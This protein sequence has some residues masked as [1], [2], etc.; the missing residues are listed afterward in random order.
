MVKFVFNIT[1]EKQERAW[2]FVAFFSLAL[3][4][5]FDNFLLGK[6]S[7]VPYA[8]FLDSSFILNLKLYAELFKK[9]GPFEWFQPLLGGMPS[10]VSLQPPWTFRT[11]LAGLMPLWLVVALIHT[12]TICIAGYGMFRLLRSYFGIDRRTSFITG[13]LYTLACPWPYNYIWACYFPLSIVHVDE[14]TDPNRRWSGR[15]VRLGLFILFALSSLPV[16][17]LP[18]FSVGHFLF[19]FVFGKSKD[20]LKHLAT[21][22]LLWTGYALLFTPYFIALFQYV[23]DVSRVYNY[24]FSGVMDAILSFQRIS[25]L[26]RENIVVALVIF[27]LPMLKIPGRIRVAFVYMIVPL[28]LCTLISSDFYYYLQDTFIIKMDLAHSIQLFYFGS[29]LYCGL[30]LHE[31]RQGKNRIILVWAVV[32]ILLLRVFCN[33]AQMIRGGAVVAFALIAANPARIAWSSSRKLRMGF[34]AGAACLVCAFLVLKQRE[35]LKFTHVPFARSFGEYSELERIARTQEQYD[36]RV[37]CIDLH[38]SVARYYG[39]DALGSRHVLTNKYYKEYFSQFM[40]PMFKEE[41]RFKRFIV[42]QY[43]L[44]TTPRMD[45][46]DDVLFEAYYPDMK[47]SVADWNMPM[48]L[49]AGV[50]YIVSSKPIEGI[51]QYADGVITD[52]GVELTGLFANTV[53][54]DYYSLP[55]LIYRVR[56]PIRLA[57]FAS[58]VIVLPTRDAVF[59]SMIDAGI[60]GMQSTLF[61]Y[62][63]DFDGAI[64]S[65]MG[66][67]EVTEVRREMDTMSVKGTATGPGYVGL[68]VNYDPRWVCTVNGVKTPIFR[69]N[70]SFQAV[71]VPGAGEFTLKFEYHDPLVSIS[72]FASA[73]GIMLLLVPAFFNAKPSSISVFPDAKEGWLFDLGDSKCWHLLAL[74]GVAVSVLWVIGFYFFIFTRH[75]GDVLSPHGYLFFKIPVLGLL[76]TGWICVWSYLGRREE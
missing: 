20:K 37:A 60:D 58:K 45:N 15:I 69:T 28:F 59:E 49:A 27:L 73:I 3:I 13:I 8:D 39:L 17:T 23:P 11:V 6:Y 62:S 65:Q 7:L 41:G 2:A 53:V 32:S 56:K 46:R 5:Y 31:M 52:H 29:V 42:Q 55:I 26:M 70:H 72:Y 30:A 36:F 21:I 51:E 38:P 34:L 10:L 35:M 66:H 48:L 33:E 14:L 71:A 54:D 67:G 25:P 9:H 24:S 64:N 76:L 19:V 63:G 68:A 74:G 57:R 4:L 12:F 44:Y 18:E 40:K 61:L 47:R 75:S 16:L 43:D 1:G 22:I 50:K